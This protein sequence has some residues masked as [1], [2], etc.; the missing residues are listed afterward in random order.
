M[1]RCL[2]THEDL[3]LEIPT[4]VFESTCL[5]CVGMWFKSI[6]E[7][8]LVVGD[9]CVSVYARDEWMERCGAVADVADVCVWIAIVRDGCCTVDSTMLHAVLICIITCAVMFDHMSACSH[10]ATVACT[11]YYNLYS[12]CK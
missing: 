2:Q 4:N 10:G 1:L 7:Y 3:V 6:A 8:V 9:V 11:C 12:Y 5:D